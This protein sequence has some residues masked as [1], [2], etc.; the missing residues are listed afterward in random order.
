V[1][2]HG[3]AL[4][5]KRAIDVTLA[6]T[7]L[8][9]SAPAIAAAAVA[10]R[11]TAGSPVFFRQRRPGRHGRAFE[12]V[13]FRTMNDARDADGKLL[14]DEQRLTKVGAFLRATSVDELPQLWNVLR[15]EMSLVGPRPL[16]M[17][18]LPRYSDE[19]ARRHDVL[20][21]ITGWAQINGR[22]TLAWSE[23]FALDVWY[24]DHWTPWLDVLIL[25]KT[26]QRVVVREG[27]SSEG[28]ATMP[29]FMGNA[30]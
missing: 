11:L 15:G 26:T 12:V 22:N 6:G 16:L 14:P 28:H 9:V 23:K 7:G 29:E 30:T 1:R 27:I 13:K 2:Q 21:G 3:L 20:P 4:A 19:Q 8:L 18:Y 24:V 5:L 10:T 25:A 17:Q